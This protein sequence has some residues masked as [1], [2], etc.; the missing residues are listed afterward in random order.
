MIT[1]PTAPFDLI[2]QSNPGDSNPNLFEVGETY[3]VSWSGSGGGSV[4]E[5]AV[6]VRSDAAPGEGG[7]I[8]FEGLDQNGDLAQIVWTPDFDLEGWYFDNFNGGNSPGFYTS[9]RD[10]S[11]THSFVCFAAETTI[12]TPTGPRVVA[13]LKPGDLVS[14]QDN[15]PQPVQW[16]EQRTVVGT[17]R[18]AP[19][20][21]A[22]GTIGNSH[23]LRLSQQHRVMI[24]SPLAELLFA[25]NEV[26]V[27]A[28]AMTGDTGICYAPTA[29]ITYVHFLLPNHEI[30]FAN[31]APCESLLLGDMA[32]EILHDGPAEANAPVPQIGIQT[33]CRP[34]LTYQEAR[35][36]FGTRLPKKQ[37]V[38][39]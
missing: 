17:G 3:D 37:K 31:G 7:I 28:K 21:F 15:G 2:V 35:G 16:I 5:D 23:P 33:A 4:L 20:I 8:V 9:D 26:F 14:T 30:V 6:V 32:Q 1:R 13:S 29:C 19:V 12:Q 27:P 11:Y 38:V 24:R 34:V 10:S 25:C 39:L 18:N 36:I 22:A